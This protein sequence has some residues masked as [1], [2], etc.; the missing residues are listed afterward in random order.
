MKYIVKNLKQAG[1][2]S[3]LF[4]A[5][6]TNVQ[7][8]SALGAEPVFNYIAGSIG[9][10]D[11]SR[12][13]AKVDLGNDVVFPG[14]VKIDDKP[15]FSLLAGRQYENSKYE[16][17]YQR[18]GYKASEIMLNGLTQ[19]VSSSG[20]YQALTLNAYR[21]HEFRHDL[22][23]SLGIGVGWGEAKLPQLGFNAGCQCFPAASNSGFV[24]Q[25]RVG[26]EY[27]VGQLNRLGISYT[28]L[29]DM[30]GPESMGETPRISYPDKDIGTLA[31]TLRRVL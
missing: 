15:A 9:K 1:F 22:E 6:V 5:C 18:G 4:A 29:F 2:A 13:D 16:I 27:R 20:S 14:E 31:I 17:E 11:I 28:Y 7:A 23:G 19:G 26:F 3:F 24:W 8:Q 10:H 12:W 25:L 21:L 30:K